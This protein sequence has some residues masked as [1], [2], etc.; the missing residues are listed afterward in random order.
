MKSQ[1]KAQ[2]LKQME[3]ERETE[4]NKWLDFNAKTFSKTSKGK[5]KKSIFATPDGMSGRVGVGTC[6]L[7]G[8]P[9]TAYQ[10]QEKWK[11]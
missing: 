3:E 4:K 10:M 9:M 5:V 7:S 2:R 1:K 11:K 8:K 6:G